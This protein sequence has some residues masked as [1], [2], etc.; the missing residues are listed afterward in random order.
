VS[1]FHKPQR[2]R[3]ETCQLSG[4]E[5]PRSGHDL[6]M[7]REAFWQRTN[8]DRGQDYAKKSLTRSH[9]ATTSPT[10]TGLLAAPS[11]L[12]YHQA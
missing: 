3:V 12:L 5:S 10:A 8:Q 2:T 11:R 4:A 9:V 1:K 7:L 6:E